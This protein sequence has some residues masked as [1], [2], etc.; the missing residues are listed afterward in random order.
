VV[1]QGRFQP[2]DLMILRYVVHQFSYFLLK[3]LSGY[4]P[5]LF[6]ATGALKGATLQPS[7]PTDSFRYAMFCQ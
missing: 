1:Y 4:I 6:E 3:L 5:D 7:A 2:N